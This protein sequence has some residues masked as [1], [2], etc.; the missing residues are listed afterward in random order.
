[1]ASLE[2]FDAEKVEP[3]TGF[4]PIPDNEYTAMIVDSEV[5]P[6]KK[7]TGKYLNLSLEVV[8]GPYRG[9]RLWDML[10]LWNPSAEAVQIAE[11]TLSAICRSIGVMRPKESAELHNKVLKIKVAIEPHSEK[12]NVF[13]NKVKR[14]MPAN[15]SSLTTTTASAPA[16][17]G[18]AAPKAQAEAPWKKKSA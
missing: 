11:A 12:P 13:Q 6:T 4:D 2:G 18:N 8:D 15:G 7:G 10:N 16:A 3:S 5:K 1:M 9:R 14:Y 17:N